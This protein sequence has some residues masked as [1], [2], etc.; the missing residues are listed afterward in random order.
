M[1]HRGKRKGRKE[2]MPALTVKPVAA[3]IGVVVRGGEVLL[4]RRAN[5]PEAGK[6]GFP[7]GKIEPGEPVLVAAA[8][9]RFKAGEVIG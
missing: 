3:V 5:Q 4:V 2:S 6:W 8:D 9:M 7:G 1:S